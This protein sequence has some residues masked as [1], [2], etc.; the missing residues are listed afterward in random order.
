MASQ[1]SFITK[2]QIKAPV[3]RVWE[4]IYNS[5][6]WRTWWKGVLQVTDICNGDENGIGDVKNI[7]WKS[8]LPYKLSFKMKLVEKEM[9]KKLTGIAFGELQGNGTWYF[10]QENDITYVEY[11]WNVITTKKWMNVL[12]F[13]L[14]PAFKY[15]H[16]VVMHWGAEGLAKKLN[17]ELVSY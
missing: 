13:I 6:N 8:V 5:N 2:W 10:K 9:Y 7:T 17:A 14:K 15:N 1:Y 11:Y 16:N 12:S 4:A 3:E